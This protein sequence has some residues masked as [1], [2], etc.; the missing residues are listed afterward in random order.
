MQQK[1]LVGRILAACARGE[2]PA[3][4]LVRQVGGEALVQSALHHR[5]SGLVQDALPPGALE[6]SSAMALASVT[7]QAR[8]VHH[9][10]VVDMAELGDVLDAA[11][12]DWLVVK[13]PAL[14]QVA[15]R[16]PGLRLYGDLDVIVRRRDFADAVTSLRA[17]HFRLADRNLRRIAE[18][19]AGQLNFVGPHGTAVDLH[20]HLLF[21]EERRRSHSIDMDSIFDRSR[22][23]VIDDRRVL[24]TDAVDSLLHVTMHACSEGAD[25]L[26]WL[27]D[28][29]NL[30]RSI[31]DWDAV[32]ERARSWR[33]SLS[34]GLVLARSRRVVAA[35]IPA[36]VIRSLLPAPLRAA[37]AVV[38]RLFPVE[39]SSGR[40]GS[41]A[42]FI[43]R[44]TG[45]SVP[46]SVLE[47]ADRM[48]SRAGWVLRTRSFERPSGDEYPTDL[49][50]P[51][52]E[53][54]T[55]EDL[56]AF[57]RDIAEPLRPEGAGARRGARER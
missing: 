43:A 6:R 31:E 41:P 42:S 14:S 2:A 45:P 13:G 10:A 49:N 29:A 57:L 30:A 7:L 54:G 27:V 37:L 16:R 55:S 18:K 40:W 51:M 19:V 46:R 25:R 35:P 21:S 8:A 5:L 48:R 24:T 15:Y 28:T 17:A 38:D 3:I 36:W 11:G 9:R 50:S 56:D 34:T 52:A 12:T 39:R 4:D 33:T 26:V 1:R 22:A 20:W 53:V 44:S 47:L 23:V 32:V